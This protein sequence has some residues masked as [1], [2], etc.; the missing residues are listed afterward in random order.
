VAVVYSPHDQVGGDFYRAELI[1]PDTY[2]VLLADVVGHG[3]SAAL[4]TMLLRALWDEG[5]HLLGQ[6]GRF[7]N[8]LSGRVEALS[9][10]YSGYFATAVYLVYDLNT[11]DYVVAAAGHPPPFRVSI[12]G[13]VQPLNVKGPALG[14]YANPTYLEV[15]GSLPRGDQLLL[16]TD[17][18]VEVIDQS[19][20]EVGLDG[21]SELASQ[22]G[23][24]RGQQALLDIEATLLRRCQT[25]SLP[26]D[27]TLFS[28]VRK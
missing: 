21:L 5:R 22:V 27:L 25:V 18:A 10:P 15:P 26:D 9:T 12:D 13:V 23:L 11:G 8:W 3:V 14:L 16:Y 1:A 6:P 17:G 7:L 2:A 4:Y 24:M 28:L 19:G 20:R